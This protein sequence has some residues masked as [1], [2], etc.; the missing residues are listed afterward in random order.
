MSDKDKAPDDGLAEILSQEA[1]DSL[2][3]QRLTEEEQE[4]TKV[5]GKEESTHVIDVYDF[6][7]P[8]FMGETEMRRLRLLHEDFIRFLEARLSMFL[9]KEFTLKMLKLETLPYQRVI[10]TIESPAHLA[11]FRA[12]PL[13]GIGF[14]EISPRLALTVA[15]SILGGKDPAPTEARYLTKI[16]I[17][18]IEEFLFIFLQEWCSQWKYRQH[19]EPHITGHEVVASVLQICEPDTVI[20]ILLMEADVRGCT[21]QIQVAVPLYMIEPMVRHMQEQR[22]REEQFD[23]GEKVAVWRNGY[24]TVPVKASASFQIG[25]VSAH[26]CSTWKPGTF[27]P[28]DAAS[29]KDVTL[30]LAN[31]PLYRAEAGVKDGFVAVRVKE[32][33]KEAAHAR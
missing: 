27:V 9:R 8:T 28:F 21:G 5:L 17:D 12:N 1:I 16:E 14:L 18:L 11:L 13:P 31:V 22:R 19:L 30:T 26:D 23:F 6:R 10:E 2:L 29:L 20:L 3:A 33:L 32:D 15:S 7:Q 4:G 25:K 24:N